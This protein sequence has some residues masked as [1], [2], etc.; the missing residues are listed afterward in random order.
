[1]NVWTWIPVATLKNGKLMVEGEEV[2][3]SKASWKDAAFAAAV[4]SAEIQQEGTLTFA[5][6]NNHQADLD[7]SMSPAEIKTT[8]HLSRTS[9]LVQVAGELSW[10]T[11]RAVMTANFGDSDWTPIEAK[12]EC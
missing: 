12:L 2:S 3:I 11:N 6:K 9:N 5:L 10:E 7:L 8:L 4:A 1:T